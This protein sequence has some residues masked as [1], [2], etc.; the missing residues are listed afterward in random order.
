MTKKEFIQAMAKKTG[1]T[2]AQSTES[3]EAFLSVLEE[4]LRKG[5]RVSFLGFGTFNVIHKEA[6]K[7]RNP[8]TG[9][10]IDVPAKNVVRFKPGSGL[11]D[12]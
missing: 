9:E 6:G 2:Q 1:Q 8:R 11:K 12:I 4:E 5:E 3:Y 10:T 7:A